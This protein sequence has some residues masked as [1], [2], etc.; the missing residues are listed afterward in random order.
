MIAQWFDMLSVIAGIVII[1]MG[2]HFLGVFRI[3]LLYREAR[4]R[5]GPQACRAFR[6][7][8]DWAGLRLRLD[9]LRRP[10]A[11]GDPVRRGFAGGGGA[12]GGLLAVYSLGIGLSVHPGRRRSLPGSSALA[13]RFRRHMHKVEMV[14]GGFL[15]LTGILFV[16]GQMAAISYWLL[17]TFPASRTSDRN[18]LTGNF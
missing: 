3:A 16:T 11:G 12:R 10:G 4:V 15:V 1:I 2:L 14:M 5:G 8:C 9:A 7:L 18:P 13:A 6:R 17:E